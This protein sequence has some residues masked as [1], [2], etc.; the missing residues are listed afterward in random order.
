MLGVDALHSH[1]GSDCKNL[2]VALKNQ[3]IFNHICLSR[4]TPE[5]LYIAYELKEP[6]LQIHKNSLWGLDSQGSKIS[7]FPYFAPRYLPRV[8][9][10]WSE[11]ILESS[12]L[13]KEEKRR[14]K[15]AVGI[16]QSIQ[17]QLPQ[18]FY[19]QLIDLS[20]TELSQ[21]GAEEVVLTCVRDEYT[22]LL[23]LHPDY[24]DKSM[25]LFKQIVSQHTFN[26]SRLCFD[27]RIPDQ[28]T[29]R[30]REKKL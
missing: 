22:Y 18:G 17:K 11:D 27:M 30:E 8:Y 19:L 23:R 2:E 13:G 3:G 10:G 6:V 7:L 14:C 25:G 21:S 20:R 16:S 29:I 15:E 24:I 1:Y 9:F 12:H 28:I 26:S 4:V 5:T